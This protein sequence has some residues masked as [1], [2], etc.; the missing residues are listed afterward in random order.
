MHLFR[1]L[2]IHCI[3]VHFLM[4]VC[5]QKQP[6]RWNHF[7]I[8]HQKWKRECIP[9]EKPKNHQKF[10]LGK[11]MKMKSDTG[12]MTAWHCGALL[13]KRGGPLAQKGSL[14]TRKW[15]GCSITNAP[16]RILP[17]KHF[18]HLSCV[19]KC[20]KILNWM[21]AIRNYP[22][23]HIM[24]YVQSTL[25]KSLAKGCSPLRSSIRSFSQW[26]V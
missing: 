1:F 15:E 21:A 25:A 4:G 22:P 8:E 12:D 17:P 7:F 9:F 5:N 2:C 18:E 14:L 26:P 11:K 16:L 23:S 20:Q 24:V 19:C 6:V 13:C 10:E 3:V